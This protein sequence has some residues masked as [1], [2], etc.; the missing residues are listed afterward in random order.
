MDHFF[1][2]TYYTMLMDKYP[3]EWSVAAMVCILTRNDVQNWKHPNFYY[4]KKTKYINFDVSSELPASIAK[5]KYIK[6]IILKWETLDGQSF[7]CFLVRLE[8]SMEKQEKT[9]TKNRNR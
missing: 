2:K 8:L 5:V 3:Y 7:E 6:Y 4:K 9:K 1:T